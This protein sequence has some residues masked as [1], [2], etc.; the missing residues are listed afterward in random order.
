MK[1]RD[2]NPLVY[3]KVSGIWFRVIEHQKQWT[4]CTDRTGAKINLLN[5][6]IDSYES[7]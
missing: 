5:M 7:K 2:L 6:E 4:V 3:F 1:I